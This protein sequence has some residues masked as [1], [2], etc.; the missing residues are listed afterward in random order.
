MEDD[1]TGDQL[2]ENGGTDGMRAA[3]IS[4]VG[5]VDLVEVDE[6]APRPGTLTVDITLCGICGTEVGSYR[7]GVLHSPSVCGHEWVGVV[8]AVG[9]QVD[10][11]LEGERVV[12]GVC[13][14]CGSCPEC[15][16]G[17]AENCRVANRMARGKDPLAPGH[18]GFARRITVAADRVVAA[19]PALSDVQAAVVEPAAV[20]FHGIRRSSIRPGDLVAVLG[21]GPIGLLAM[22][23]ARVAGAGHVVMVEPSDRRRRLAAELGADEAVAPDEAGDRTMALSG[24]VGVDVVVEASGVPALLQT[25][26]DLTRAGGTV[27]LLSYLSRP[28]E[29]NGARIM[30]RE[31]HIVGANAYTRSDFR[32]TMDLIA[33]GRVRVEPMHTR[34]VGLA[35]LPEALADLAAGIGDDVKVLVDPTVEVQ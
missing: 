4:G 24:E 21:A 7:S 10:P 22:Q 6:A 34:T 27:T 30:A 31:T 2:P 12:I 8:S 3:L 18:G 9:A 32:R 23:F 33:D 20:A 14:P 11:G 28:S 17:Y 26:V 25:A 1:V 13:A 16:A 15:R 19:N 29:V 5:Q 35:G